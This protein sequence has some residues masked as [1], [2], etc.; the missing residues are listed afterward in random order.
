MRYPLTAIG[1]ALALTTPTLAQDA[2]V[3]F[4][5]G[6]RNTDFEP[7]FAEQ[8]RAELVNSGVETDRKMLVGGLEHPWGIAT[9]PDDGGWLVTE[10]AGNLRH[11]TKDGTLHDPISGLPEILVERQGGLLDVALD[12]D[13]AENRVIYFTYAKPLGE[14][15]S[16][17]AAARAVLAEDNMSLSEVKDI[18]VQDPPSSAPMHYGSRIVPTGDGKVFI[19]TGEHFTQEYREFAQDLD[20]TYGKVI[21]VNIDGSTPDDNP[22]VGQDGA[23]DTIWSLGHRNIQ[24]ATLDED[25]TLW[26]IEHGPKGGDELNRT[27]A[28]KNYGWPVVSYGEQYSGQPVGSGDASAEGMEQPTYFW[29]PVI[30]PAGVARVSGDAFADWEGDLLIS[31]LFPGGVVRLSQDEEGRVTE[32]E[33]LLRNIGR[34]RDIEI[35]PDGSFLVLTDFE[36]GSIFHITPK[37]NSG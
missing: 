33:R 28:G 36:N 10:R 14:G 31:S 25:G 7:A 6:N 1:L 15:M 13:F 23:A 17:T 4:T 9:L 34:V 27:E 26:T 18:F 30:A 8:F 11:V 16:G 20:K 3:T 29:D 24:G 19:T 37:K 22:F 35:Q 5:W 2:E 12:P 21:R 32:E